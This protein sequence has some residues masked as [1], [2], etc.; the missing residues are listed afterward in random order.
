MV[1][2]RLLWV[3]LQ[4][5]PRWQDSGPQVCQFETP[6]GRIEHLGDGALASCS[7]QPLLNALLLPFLTFGSASLFDC[8]ALAS[9]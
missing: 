1:W 7:Q 3:G 8:L 5:A 6:R 4:R 2:T 9:Q